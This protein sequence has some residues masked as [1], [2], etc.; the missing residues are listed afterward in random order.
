LARAGG[1]GR[2]RGAFGSASPGPAP[3]RTLLLGAGG[4]SILFFLVG[5]SQWGFVTI[6]LLVAMG[7]CGIVYTASSQTRLQLVA[8]PDLRGRVMS[9]YSLLQMGS[10]PV[11][12]FLTGFLAER[13]GVSWAIALRATGC[14]F[15]VLVAALYARRM[16]GRMMED[17]DLSATA[18]EREP[19][20]A[21]SGR[22]V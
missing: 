8:P 20:L 11:G 10:T 1:G 6:P 18:P 14:R 13:L 22:L 4:F 2:L 17:G 19:V 21:G 7:A 15:G 3:R 5:I 9:I 12:G 16:R